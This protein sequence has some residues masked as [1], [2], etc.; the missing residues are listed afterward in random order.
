MAR[1]D[2]TERNYRAWRAAYDHFNAGLFANS[3]PGCLITFQRSRN[4]YGFHAGSQFEA[5]NEKTNADEI[6]LNPRHFAER[7]PRD[8][9]AT[10]AHEMVHQH[11]W[12]FGKPSPAG[13]HNKAWA[14]HMIDIGLVPTDT[15]KPG[16]K[17]TGRRVHHFIRADGP[18]DRLCTELLKA[19]FVIPYVEP[20][21]ETRKL[22]ALRA[23]KAA[24]K[25]RYTCPNCHPF[26]HIWGK[27]GLNIVCGE[28][29]A[30][31]EAGNVDDTTQLWPM[32]MNA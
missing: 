24:S 26:K 17:A 29:G 31:F 28:C 5:R 4:A 10:L 20:N 18:F 2:P 7:E 30:H 9:L 6:A 12:H 3:L 14:R 27:P 25:S 23:Q 13:Y 15:G 1:L 11:Q 19:G 21:S 16:G 22:E 32:E 8:V